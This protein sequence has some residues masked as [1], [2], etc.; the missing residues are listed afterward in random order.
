LRL[1]NFQLIV[2][3]Y[4]S[5]SAVRPCLAEA[6]FPFQTLELSLRPTL[7]SRGL[8]A[9]IRAGCGSLDECGRY[10]YVAVAVERIDPA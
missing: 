5:M 1:D 6:E 3:G 10:R 2:L 4:T 9:F 8:R 7:R